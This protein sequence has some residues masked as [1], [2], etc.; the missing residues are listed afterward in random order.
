MG[1]R[2]LWPLF[3]AVGSIAQS[4]VGECALERANLGALRVTP[5]HYTEAIHRYAE[6]LWR[7]GRGVAPRLWFDP[8]PADYK[9]FAIPEAAALFDELR[10]DQVAS[11]LA[12]RGQEEE[13]R[14]LPVRTAQ[15]RP[16]SSEATGA[17]TERG[18]AGRGT[19]RESAM[20]APACA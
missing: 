1:I 16:G 3:L 2:W 11:I 15:V 9:S 8:A 14:R 20:R 7:A 5:V 18:E 17:G 4:P 19:R 13:S 6:A 10:Q 12:R